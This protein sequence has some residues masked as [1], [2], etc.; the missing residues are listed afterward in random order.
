MNESS[1]SQSSTHSVEEMLKLYDEA[2]VRSAYKAILGRVADPGG[3][4]NY[5]SQVRAGVDK[6]QILAELARSPEGMKREPNVHGLRQLIAEYDRSTS[7]ILVRIFRRLTKASTEPAQRQLRIVD[8][9]LYLVEQ[10]IATQANQLVALLSLL[11]EGKPQS[12]SLNSSLHV[13]DLAD[14]SYTATQTRFSP[15]VARTYTELKAT[16][17]KKLAE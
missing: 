5:L 7:S 14:A 8:N 13:S 16:I 3:L 11:H 15:N 6:V 12:D 17:A 1:P 10:V 4:A 2:F 9:R